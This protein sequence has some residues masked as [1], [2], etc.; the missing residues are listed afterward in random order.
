MNQTIALRTLGITASLTNIVPKQMHLLAH[1]KMCARGMAAL[2]DRGPCPGELAEQ[3]ERLVTSWVVSYGEGRDEAFLIKVFTNRRTERMRCC[4]NWC[5]ADLELRRGSSRG[6]TGRERGDI[7]GPPAAV[8][9]EAG[10]GAA[11]SDFGTL[12]HRAAGGLT[13]TGPRSAC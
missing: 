5:Q 2:A 11:C 7:G 8:V 6:R 9:L 1:A 13:W 3:P 4:A 10:D 12:V